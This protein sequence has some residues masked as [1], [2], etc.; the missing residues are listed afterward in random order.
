MVLRPLQQ[1]EDGPQQEDEFSTGAASCGSQQEDESLLST[2][3]SSEI[4]Q[5]EFEEE[6]LGISQV[7]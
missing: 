3:F 6:L 4:E 2:C 5:Q 7:S 1:Q